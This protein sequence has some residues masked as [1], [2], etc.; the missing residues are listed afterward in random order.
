MAALGDHGEGRPERRACLPEI[1][2][3]GASPRLA[4]LSQLTTPTRPP[5]S[6]PAVLSRVHTHT[7]TGHVPRHARGCEPPRPDRVGEHR[8]VQVGGDHGPCGPV[9]ARDVLPRH[10]GPPRARRRGAEP[11]PRQGGR[12][13]AWRAWGEGGDQGG[14]R[15]SRDGGQPGEGRAVRE[16]RKRG[17]LTYAGGVV[18]QP[19]DTEA[20]MMW[21][22]PS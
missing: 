8:A 9:Q 21:C 1:G 13:R 2:K 12:G 14:G 6:A 22:H 7:H 20:T 17:E 15:E 18:E 4:P 11:G 3:M 19:G 5:T 16:R 10:R